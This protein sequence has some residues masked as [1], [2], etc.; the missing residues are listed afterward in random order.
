MKDLT[1]DA[2]IEAVEDPQAGLG[3]PL[4][5]GVGVVELVEESLNFGV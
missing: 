4:E 2:R 5:S 3:E 1:L